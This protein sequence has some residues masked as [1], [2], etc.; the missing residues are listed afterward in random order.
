MAFNPASLLGTVP[1]PYAATWLAGRFG[2]GAVSYHRCAA[3]RASLLARAALQ[4][5]RVAVN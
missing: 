4:R 1:A 5:R 2:F 3:A